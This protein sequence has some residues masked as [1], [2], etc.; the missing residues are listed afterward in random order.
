[1]KFKNDNSTEVSGSNL[2]EVDLSVKLSATT[3][4][5]MANLFLTQLRM[6]IK[7]NFYIR[8]REKKMLIMDILSPVI[9]MVALI[10]IMKFI[11]PKVL[12]AMPLSTPAPI[13]PAEFKN[14]LYMPDTKETKTIIDSLS[15]TFGKNTSF[16]PTDNIDD[17]VQKYKELQ[18][19][20]VG[21]VFDNLNSSTK[22]TYSLRFPDGSVP[23]KTSG[24]FVDED[25]CPALGE[26][27]AAKYVSSGYIFLQNTLDKILAEKLNPNSNL[28]SPVMMTQ[29]MPKVVFHQ[30]P[31]TIL[32]ITSIYFIVAFLSFINSLCTHLVVEKEKKIRPTMQAMG[33][34]ETAFW[35]SWAIVQYFFTTCVVVISTI[36]IVAINVLPNSNVFLF[37]LAL[38]FFTLTLIT[39]SFLLSTFFKKSQTA[40]TLPAFY[41]FM[42]TLIYLAIGLTRTYSASTGLVYTTPKWA[43]VLVCLVSPIAF[44]LYVD[45]TISMDLS[46]VGMNFSTMQDGY[47]PNYIPMLMLLLDAVLYYFLS[48]Y[49][50][51]V[52]SGDFKRSIH[53]CFCLFPSYWRKSKIKSGID[54]PNFDI[55]FNADIKDNVEKVPQEFDSKVG[56]R[57][58]RL[59]KSFKTTKE[60]ITAVDNISLNMYEDEITCLLGHNGAGKTTLINMLTGFLKPDSGHA[61]IYGYDVANAGNLEKLKTM[62]GLCPQENIIHD[63]LTCKENL[64][65]F[66]ALKGFSAEEIEDEID[67]LLKDLNLTEKA[68]VFSKNLSG[69]QKRKLSVGMAFIGKPKVIFL[70]EPTAG[71]DPL[72]RRNMWELLKKYKKNHCILLTTHFMDEADILSDRKAI[73]SKGKLQ[74]YGSSLFLKYNYGIGY[75]LNLL[76]DSDGDVGRIQQHMDNLNAS[77]KL[78]RTHG[79][80]VAF[81]IP[82]KQIDQ[83]RF[84]DILRSLEEKEN[85]VT[86]AEN[87]GIK[88]YGVSMTTLE[89]VFFQIGQE[90]TVKESTDEPNDDENAP[91]TNAAPVPEVTYLNNTSFQK[92]TAL[93]KVFFFNHIR[94]P[95]FVIFGMVL[96]NILVLASLLINKYMDADNDENIPVQLDI[97]SLLYDYAGKALSAAKPQFLIY[98]TTTADADINNVTADIANVLSVDRTN[99]DL[100]TVA[101]HY[102]GSNFY[103]HSN[104]T[105]QTNQLVHTAI[106]NSTAVH[107]IPTIANYIT[108][109]LMNLGGNFSV[110]NI[111][112]NN[113][114]WPKLRKTA[115]VSGKTFATVYTLS[116]AFLFISNGVGIQAVKDYEFHLR[117]QLRVSGVSNTIYWAAKRTIDLGNALIPVI[118]L[119]IIIL[120]F[121]VENLNSAGSILCLVLMC[122]IYTACNE[123][124]SYLLSYAFTSFESCQ[125]VSP[126]IS[127][128]IA[129]LPSYAVLILYMFQYVTASKAIHYVCSIF[130]PPYIIFGGIFFIVMVQMNYNHINKTI[131]VAAPI[132]DFFKWDNMVL[133]SILITLFHVIWMPFLINA[134]DI[135]KATGKL[136]LAFGLK[137]LPVSYDALKD[138]TVEENEDVLVER[139]RV[140]NLVKKKEFPMATVQK[141]SKI[142]GQPDHVCFKSK[143]APKNMKVAVNDVSFCVKGGEVLGL[144]GPNGAGKTTCISMMS[145]EL[146]IDK[147]K[148]FIRDQNREEELFNEMI[149]FCP[150]HDAL[151]PLSTLREQIQCYAELRGICKEDVQIVVD[152]Y[153]ETMNIK[154]HANNYTSKLS[155][156]TKRKTSYI[157]SMIGNPHLVLFDEPSTGM[158]PK[159]KRFMWDIISSNFRDSTK[160]AILTT[161]Y[162]EEAETLCSRVAIIVN[163][164]MQCVGST[165]QLKEKYGQGYQLEVKL[166]VENPSDMEESFQKLE[167]HLLTL[168]PSMTTAE[169]ITERRTYKIPSSEAAPLS[170]SFAMLQEAKSNFDISEYSFS[171]ATLEQ[172]FLQFAR[173]Q[174]DE[175]E[176]VVED[177]TENVTV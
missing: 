36:I 86:K 34:Q 15:Q 99:V 55:E 61:M 13:T 132:E 140:D 126:N 45:N 120:A 106:F 7:R 117:S 16:T 119:L 31:T 38:M 96:P 6:L 27:K 155:G 139:Q 115:A 151:F 30:N 142:F 116:F 78:K 28:T 156:G 144:L 150:Q 10:A 137:P 24:V 159:S 26:C 92:Y 48:V 69:G 84:P 76:T 160:G 20:T 14:I 39:L 158:D 152:Y 41:V 161:H 37:F 4:S 113:W 17:M 51:K 88:S 72:S 94:H 32:S 3:R 122:F 91:M 18:G 58:M 49:L 22:V 170:K 73:I 173:K 162:M 64:R 77:I 9:Y 25:Q 54:N 79:S 130:F 60:T 146:G 12:P 157:M 42:V 114:P 143:K 174:K 44:A 154:E 5:A 56:I 59:L 147:G 62:I 100:L 107:A 33:L 104:Q 50:E 23:D 19:N 95:M 101:P 171:Q 118:F 8:I 65:T 66:A 177:D 1:M 169:A 70:D 105:L 125:S 133:Y 81:V 57:I 63:Q 131:D 176:I 149:G 83:N 68:D 75:H 47:F 163:G 90:E 141:I 165:Q 11:R 111:S 102:I 53:P 89:D 148:I 128:T 40:M 172:V 46:G 43:M 167:S 129:L 93:F 138:Q 29:R 71:V 112:T 145:G 35:L 21:V 98:N 74:C 175:N 103:W 164:R 110:F 127:T 124:F 166:N 82:Q 123:Q 153:L 136:R 108:N 85:D 109:T 97:T 168:F 67:S 2:T 135:W 80:E 87:L 52:I 134:L 121:Q